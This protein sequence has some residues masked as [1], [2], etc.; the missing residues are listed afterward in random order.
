M[1]KLRILA[2][3]DLPTHKLRKNT[4]VTVEPHV[5]A[6]WIARKLA[7]V[8]TPEPENTAAPPVKE[9]RRART[10]KRN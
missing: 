7:E 4:V 2:D 10:S 8:H 6:E 9:T 1:I 3:A 5:G